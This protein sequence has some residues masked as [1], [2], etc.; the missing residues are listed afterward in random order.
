[1]SPSGSVF[2]WVRWPRGVSVPGRSPVAAVLLLT[3]LAVGLVGCSLATGSTMTAPTAT[4]SVAKGCPN[5]SD[6]GAGV[7]APAHVLTMKDA[8]HVSEA[9]VGDVVQVRLPSAQRWR[10]A[11]DGAGT[12]EL[13]QPAGYGD[14]KAGACVWNFR[15]TKVGATAVSFGGMAICEPGRL[16]P[17]YVVDEE[18]RITVV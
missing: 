18:F 7:T 17:Q 1:M 3:L 15:A 16:C 2:E 11:N 4:T 14:V 13:L 8:G 6:S 9:H 10:F 12:L 5:T